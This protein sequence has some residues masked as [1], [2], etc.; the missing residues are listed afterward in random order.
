MGQNQEKLDDMKSLIGLAGLV[1]AQ[2]KVH[3]PVATAAVNVEAP[4]TK[5]HE[6]M[7]I[8]RA[9]AV[10]LESQGVDTSNLTIADDKV[11]TGQGSLVDAY[12]NEWSV[13]DPA[14]NKIVIAWSVEDNYPWTEKTIA[15]ME[16]MGRDLGCL[17]TV[18]VPRE[19]L[20]STQWPHGLMFA[21][22]ANNGGCWSALG[23][24]SGYTGSTRWSRIEQSGAPSGWQP[25]GM[26][27]DCGGDSAATVMHEVLHALGVGHEH[28]RPDRDNYLKAP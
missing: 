4:H 12:A 14:D 13:R 18:Y 9:T 16:R 2:T 17:K 22:R 20:A 24:V 11:P 23:Q 10:Q 7:H 27:S 15:I 6:C 19:E 26:S 28:N 21:N 25:I 5:V 1:S 8:N 3:A